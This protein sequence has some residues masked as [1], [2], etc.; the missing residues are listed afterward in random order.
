MAWRT[1]TPFIALALSL[2]LVLP[3]FAQGTTGP[4]RARESHV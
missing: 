3:A 2:L 4:L 1:G